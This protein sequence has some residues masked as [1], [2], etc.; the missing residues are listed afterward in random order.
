MKN[1]TNDFISIL[2]SY[3]L[4]AKVVSIDHLGEIQSEIAKTKNE[5]RDVADNLGRYLNEFSYEAPKNLSNAKSI[6]IVAVPQPIVRITFTLGIKKHVVLMPP[7]YLLNSSLEQESK[8]KKI[9]EV[10]SILEKILSPQNYKAIKTN[11]PCKLLAVKSGLSKYGRNNISY[12]KDLGSFY[13]LGAYLSD[14]P[15]EMDSWGE[16]SVMDICE[17]CNL[18]LKNCPTGAIANDRFLIHADKCI[19]LHNESTRVFPEWIATKWHNS[20]IGCMRCQLICPANKN[21]IKALEDLVE[22]SASETK[23][24]LAGIPLAELPQITYEKLETLS[25]VECFDLLSRNLKVL[26]GN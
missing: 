8:Q 9:L 16:A 13:W 10:S 15:C 26:I 6:I 25:F 14:L 1:V 18:C 7:M 21:H 2:E 11:L 24:I 23:M 5:N 19:T 20:I 22:F 4:K 17:D 12:I 3:G